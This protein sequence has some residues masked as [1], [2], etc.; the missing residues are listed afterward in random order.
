MMHWTEESCAKLTSLHK[1]QLYNTLC[2]TQV[3]MQSSKCP[4]G[5]S[6]RLSS[7]A[8]SF[9]DL[10][11]ALQDLQVLLCREPEDPAGGRFGHGYCRVQYPCPNLPLPPCMRDS[12]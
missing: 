12:R 7:L 1:L 11:V 9:L 5:M 8:S 3:G 2:N 4:P 10:A 6:K